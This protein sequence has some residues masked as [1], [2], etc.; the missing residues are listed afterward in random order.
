MILTNPIFSKEVRL[1]ILHHSISIGISLMVIKVSAVSLPV[2]D[3]LLVAGWVQASEL[4]RRRMEEQRI[5]RFITYLLES[6][7]MN[8]KALN[9]KKRSMLWEFL[10]CPKERMEIISSFSKRRMVRSFWCHR[11]IPPG[12]ESSDG[13]YY[14][15][16]KATNG[17]V[18]GNS[19]MYQGVSGVTA[20]IH[21][22]MANAPG[23][24]ILEEKIREIPS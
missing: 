10:S 24:R 1:S 5:T 22:V 8:T 15:N 12:M 18:I 7:T 9:Y 19:Q 16:L 17:Q 21:S 2:S 20:G 23:A 13:R 3:P 14:F 11:D 4:E 6:Q